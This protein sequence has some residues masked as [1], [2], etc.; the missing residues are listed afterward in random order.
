MLVGSS[1]VLDLRRMPDVLEVY[2]AKGRGCLNRTLNFIYGCPLSDPE[3]DPR[4]SVFL[5]FRQMTI[6]ESPS[7]WGFEDPSRSD[8]SQ[9]SEE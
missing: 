1:A 6:P 8:E 5:E 3:N 7:F 4:D 9:V 2:V